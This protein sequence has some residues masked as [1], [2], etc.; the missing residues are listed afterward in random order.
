M[1]PP[2]GVVIREGDDSPRADRPRGE[3]T[4]REGGRGSAGRARRETPRK[5]RPNGGPRRRLVR[6]ARAR[7]TQPPQRP[8]EP[9]AVAPPRGARPS[10]RR[11]RGAGSSESGGEI[12]LRADHPRAAATSR[13]RGGGAGKAGPRRRV[14]HEAR[15]RG[16]RAQG[17]RSC[18]ARDRPSR[19]PP[20][21]R[22]GA[23]PT[24]RSTAAGCHVDIPQHRR[25]MPRGYSVATSER[26]H[27]AASDTKI[28]D[29]ARRHP[30]KK[31]GK[32]STRTRRP[33]RSASRRS[34]WARTARSRTS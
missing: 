4:R 16:R 15:A 9:G 14:V 33:R 8:F 17:R 11:G 6:G 20:R 13:P 1:A 26:I 18:A 23:R 10:R 2:R 28:N 30:K 31:P 19:G 3:R 27:G 25:G 5:D 22:R 24:G 34:C 32:I 12:S 21:R 7:E 29:S